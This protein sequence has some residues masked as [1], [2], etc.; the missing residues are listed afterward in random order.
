M[1]SLSTYSEEKIASMSMI[2]IAY[3]LLK[4]EKSTINFYDLLKKVAELKNLNVKQVEER[5]AQFYTEVNIDGRFICLGDNMWG[6]RSWYPFEQ[7]DD[8]ISQTTPTKKKKKKKKKSADFELDDEFDDADEEDYDEEEDF[9]ADDAE[10]D[11]DSDADDDDSDDDD[12]EYDDDMID[13]ADFD[14]DSEEEDLDNDEDED[15]DAEEED[16][17]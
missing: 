10:E 12:E 11:F 14:V 17:L 13:E 9:E 2:E 6:L 15:S 16:D 1:L 8:D 7:I 3:Y 4:E 5:M